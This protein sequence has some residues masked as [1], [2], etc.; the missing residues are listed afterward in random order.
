MKVAEARAKSLSNVPKFVDIHV[1]IAIT[2][3]NNSIKEAVN[4]GHFTTRKTL[5]LPNLVENDVIKTLETH[6]QE[7]GYE[8]AIHSYFNCK[9]I[10]VSWV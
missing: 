9:L 3:I 7:L 10:Q 6:Y 4:V 5:A 2:G 8:V 1:G